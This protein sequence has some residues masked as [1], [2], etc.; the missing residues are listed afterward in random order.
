MK[1]VSINKACKILGYSKQAYFKAK[2]NAE[3]KSQALKKARDSNQYDAR[4]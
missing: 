2:K 4:R 3:R 1:I